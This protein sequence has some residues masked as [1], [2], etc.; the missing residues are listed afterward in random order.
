LLA[1]LTGMK[2]ALGP[3]LMTIRHGVTRFRIEMVC[4][5]AEFESGAFHSS[6]YGNGVWLHPEELASHP[7]GA[8]QRR[9]I[10]ALVEG[11]QRNLF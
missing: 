9:L 1:E 3:E 6:F 10:R 4:F 11:G 7:V 8:P 5:E 2:G